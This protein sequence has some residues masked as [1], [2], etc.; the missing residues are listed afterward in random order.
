MTSKNTTTL[1]L[2]S[3][4]SSLAFAQN[5]GINGTGATPD[6]SAGLDLDFNDKGFL[7]PRVTTTQRDNI[8]APATGL[9]VYNLDCNIVNYYNGTVWLALGN[10]GSVTTPGAIT[11]NT[12]VAENATGETY[13]ITAVTGAT[14]YNWTV[15]TGAT[16]TAGQGTTGITVDFG[17]TDGNVCVTANNACGTSNSSCEAITIA[18]PCFDGSTAIVTVTGAGGAVWMDRNLGATQAATSSTDAVAYGDSYQWGR[19]RKA[20]KAEPVPQQLPMPPLQYPTWVTLGMG[21][22]SQKQLL[23]LIG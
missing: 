11:G 5:I 6:A 1:S 10:V 7:M 17:T 8:G 16:I 21:Y 20:M 9:M 15:P 3:S 14:G 22:L 12:T 2:F 18:S 19:L 23:L 13:S 4:F